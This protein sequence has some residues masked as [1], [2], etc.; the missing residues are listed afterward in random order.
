MQ[1]F[2]LCEN[3]THAYYKNQDGAFQTINPT[4]TMGDKIGLLCENIP[5]A[6]KATM[7]KHVKTIKMAHCKVFTAITK[8]VSERI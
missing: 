6:L 7:D 2:P 1:A 8:V 5:A 4:P 3:S